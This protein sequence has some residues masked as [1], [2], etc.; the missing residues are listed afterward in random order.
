MRKEGTCIHCG[1]PIT[2]GKRRNKWIPVDPKPHPEGRW[3][4]QRRHF[5]YLVGVRLELAQ[6]AHTALHTTHQCPA[7]QQTSAP[8][9]D[10]S[11][12]D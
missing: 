4:R 8:G 9:F 7:R 12:E 3:K 6:I 11:K 1:Q 10:V 2:W 5:V